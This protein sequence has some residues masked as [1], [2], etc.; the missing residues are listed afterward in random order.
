LAGSGDEDEK[1][2][3]AEAEAEEDRDLRKLVAAYVRRLTLHP[4]NIRAS[5][6][7]LLRGVESSLS[8]S[9]STDN[10]ASCGDFGS[11]TINAHRRQF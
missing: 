7:R 1:E 9:R 2:D 6:R 5:S 3:E 8:V 10:I 11:T 4:G